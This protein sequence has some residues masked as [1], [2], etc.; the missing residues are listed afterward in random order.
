[1]TVA[2]KVLVTGASGFVGSAVARRLVQ[3]GF[4]VRALVR[5]TSPRAHLDDLDLEF[6][7][8]DLRDANSLRRAMQ[9]VR[10]LPGG[11]LHDR[12]QSTARASCRSRKSSRS[13]VRPTT[14]TP[15]VCCASGDSIRS[16]RNRTP[17]SAAR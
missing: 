10:Y 7:E 9:G 4:S 11:P 16:V 8:G 5:T 17:K 14:S 13:F 6:A 1:M 15:G 12:P 3:E 2:E